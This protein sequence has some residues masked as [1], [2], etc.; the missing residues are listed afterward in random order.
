MRVQYFRIA[1]RELRV[2]CSLAVARR[3]ATSAPGEAR[4]LLAS[5]RRD[6]RRL[7][8]ERVG[9]AQALASLLAAG[10]DHVQGDAP[11]ARE[12]LRRAVS[13]LEAVDMSL[14]AA[15][16]R[17]RLAHLVDGRDAVALAAD[18]QAWL[19]RHDIVAPSRMIAMLT[20]AFE[21]V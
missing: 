2:R 21:P 9:W 11:A 13:A 3:R 17:H 14:F 4:A 12:A 19:A 8:K 6:I 20:P 7:R 16:A 15:V 5:A 10:C 18:A 1:M